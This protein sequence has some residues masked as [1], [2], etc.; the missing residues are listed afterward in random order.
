[1]SPTIIPSLNSKPVCPAVHLTPPLRC[2][3]NIADSIQ[4][5][6]N[7]WYYSHHQPV[8]YLNWGFFDPYTV[9]RLRPKTVG[10]SLTP[11]LLSLT[12][13]IRKS[14]PPLF[15]TLHGP[16]YPQN[17]SPASQAV[18]PKLNPVSCSQITPDIWETWG[19]LNTHSGAS[20]DAF[21]HAGGKLSHTSSHF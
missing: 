1:M 11:P 4:S 10:S 6:P 14:L 12:L 15:Q 17:R 7:S 19:F 16:H 13:H 3:W 2:L 9:Y 8:H 18:I 20:S 21:E 5:K